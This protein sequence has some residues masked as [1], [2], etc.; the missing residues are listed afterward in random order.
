LEIKE[1]I[2]SFDSGGLNFFLELREWTSVSTLVLFKELKNFLDSFSTE[3]LANE[4]QVG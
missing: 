2:V 4:V 3:L 1:I